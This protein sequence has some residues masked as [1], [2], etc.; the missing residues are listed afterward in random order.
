[1]QNTVIEGTAQEIM[2]QLAQMPPGERVRLMIEHPS[3]SIIVR[4]L[5]ATAT[6]NGKIEKINYD[7]LKSLQKDG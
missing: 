1:M 2:A 4:R 5:Q 3:Q 6:S 7:L